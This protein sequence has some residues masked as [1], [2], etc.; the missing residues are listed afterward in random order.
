MGYGRGGYGI[1]LGNT[2]KKDFVLLLL[3]PPLQS[4]SCGD[5]MLRLSSDSQC[6]A[7]PLTII[8]MATDA[9][10]PQQC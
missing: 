3:A 4:P 6:L 7:L 10:S 5:E 2:S 9:A 1:Q 8:D